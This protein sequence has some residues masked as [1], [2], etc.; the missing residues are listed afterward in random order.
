MHP[1]F[2]Y[3][4]QQL[5]PVYE[6]RE[7][8]AMARI[9]LTEWFGVSTTAL[10]TDK[11][12]YFTPAQ[13]AEV[14]NI[15]TRL[16]NHEP[17]Q[18]IIGKVQF[19]DCTLKVTPDVL[20]PRPET[21]ELIQWIISECTNK[22]LHLLDIG[23]GSGCIPIAIGHSQPQ[24][25]IEAWDI[26]EAA[27]QVASENADSNHVQI[28]FK[29]VDILSKHL[30]DTQY[31]IIVSNP[32]YITE[33]EKVDMEANVL[34]WEPH[35]ALF[36]PHD[37]ALIFYRHIAQYAL[38]KLN[39]GGLLFFECN[40]V[41]ALPVV[42]YLEQNGFTDVEVRKDLSGNDRMIKAIRP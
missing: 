19:M 7:A 36:A 10:F 2:T 17:L 21:A 9:I 33:A 14:E 5:C 1:V 39:A 13:N 37:D 15:L 12:N 40:R 35:L 3:I 6:P 34:D 26:S 18:Y 42:Q 38:D 32:P 4:K 25:Q 31:D 8:D 23:T 27:L 16:L 29:Q 11:D 22:R 24:L 30:P 20:I 41:Y 28:R